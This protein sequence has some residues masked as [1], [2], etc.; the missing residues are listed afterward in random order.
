M[1]LPRAHNGLSAL[2]QFAKENPDLIVLD[3]S[4]PRMDGLEVC[5]RIRMSI[6]MC[7]SLC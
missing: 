1:R 6:R 2:E 7:R 4:L 3:W 5:T